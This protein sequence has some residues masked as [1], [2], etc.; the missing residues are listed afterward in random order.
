MSFRHAPRRW[1]SAPN[2]AYSGAVR[3]ALKITWIAMVSTALG[4]GVQA[5]LRLTRELQLIEED[6]LR[7]HRLIGRAL[8]P[9]L[10]ATLEMQGR[11]AV[12]EALSAAIQSEQEIQLNLVER[13]T[14]DAALH[15]PLSRDG[16]AWTVETDDGVETYTSYLQLHTSEAPVLRLQQ[17]STAKADFEA[18]A[19]REFL[20][21]LS[22]LLAATTVVAAAV[23]YSMVGRRVERLI[24]SAKA[25]S[26]GDFT[27]RP[28]EGGWDEVGM[29][30][31]AMGAMITQLEDARRTAEEAEAHRGTLVQRLRH[32]DRLATLGTL[33]SR[34]AHDI[35]TP[36]NVIEARAKMIAR[37]EV[38]GKAVLD[39]AGII[40]TQSESIAE[41]VREV[42]RFARIR[43]QERERREIGALLSETRVL[44]ESLARARGV[45]LV[46]DAPDPVEAA[47]YPIQL[48]QAIVNITVNA[49]HASP[50]GGRIVSS[51]RV[52]DV[53]DPPNRVR[54]G[55]F[56]RIAVRDEGPGVSPEVEARLFEPFFTTKPSGSGTGLG[57]PIA[58]DIVRE[59]G[60]YIEVSNREP[61]GAE[62]AILLPMESSDA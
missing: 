15:E 1:I 31:R 24:R 14:V 58:S 25:V 23:G 7:D 47:V 3:L 44:V 43:T 21:L 55:R 5:K 34:F 62:F 52:V 28:E 48:Q 61:T 13:Q 8:E 57:L 29:L 11:E 40:A 56:V 39:A 51:V 42:L 50:R 18:A 22:L 2:E 35:G 33:A 49:V 4:L 6:M 41:R 60:G 53:A 59:H 20:Y 54:A 30:S 9:S 46:V 12:D 36:L 19:L 16:L 37:Q 45:S 27:D 38:E 26:K 10:E 17:R 32:A